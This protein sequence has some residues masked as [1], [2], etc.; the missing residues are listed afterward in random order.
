MKKE[1]GRE[2]ATRSGA[3]PLEARGAAFGLKA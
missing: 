2:K 3:L 1:P